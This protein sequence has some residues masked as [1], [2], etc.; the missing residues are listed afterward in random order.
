MNANIELPMWDLTPEIVME[1]VKNFF[2]TYVKQYPNDPLLAH[3]T[4]KRNGDISS[5]KNLRL[6]SKSFRLA[7]GPAD[8]N[9]HVGGDWCRSRNSAIMLKNHALA[10][11]LEKSEL[12]IA[13]L[14]GGDMYQ[15][16]LTQYNGYEN[17]R[18]S[19][20][21]NRWNKKNFFG[22]CDPLVPGAAKTSTLTFYSSPIR[23]NYRNGEVSL[24]DVDLFGYMIPVMMNPHALPSRMSISSIIDSLMN[25]Q[26]L[27]S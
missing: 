18:S 27:P 25:P 8:I 13:C 10:I 24:G 21:N 4:V 12:Q 26:T 16:A 19:H 1:I 5:A 17:T 23:V 22:L 9:K 3:I 11:R 6:V 20:T 2:S 15:K 7:Y 14:P